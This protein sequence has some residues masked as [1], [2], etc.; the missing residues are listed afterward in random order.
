MIT[1][2]NQKQFKHSVFHIY[3]RI[4]KIKIPCEKSVCVCGGGIWRVFFCVSFFSISQK[5]V[6]TSLKKLLDPRDPTV[7]LLLEGD[8]Y[9]YF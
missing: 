3:A 6:R 9:Q 1:D 8:P 4:Q 2:G 5:A 7:Q